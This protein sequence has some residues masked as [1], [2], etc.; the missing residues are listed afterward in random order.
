MVP[1]DF[2]KHHQLQHKKS[3]YTGKGL[4]GL[5]NTGNTCYMNTIIQC[6][7]N[8]LKLT[9][10]FLNK[11]PQ[12]EDPGR[13]NWN[14]FEYYVVLSYQN[15]LHN[16]WSDNQL[17][18]PRT[19]RENLCK[20]VKKYYNSTQQDAHECLTNILDIL[21][22]AL[23]YDI[24]VDIKGTPQTSVDHLMIQ[25]LQQWKSFYEKKYSAL[26]DFFYGQHHNKIICSGC[27]AESHNFD[28]YCG[29]S[30]SLSLGKDKGSVSLDD[31]FKDYFSQ[32]QIQTWNC[33][34]CKSQ[35]CTR[36]TTLWT[37]P[38]YLIVHLKRF[39][40][41]NNKINTPVIS[42]LDDLDL[43]EYMS[44][45]KSDPNNYIYSCYA[46]AHHSGNTNGGHYWADCR[47]LDG[48]WYTFNDGDVSQTKTA[49][50][51]SIDSNRTA[52]I[53]FYHRKFM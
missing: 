13:K 41:N 42:N 8:T 52:Y 15:L 39:D 25:S 12:E 5:M 40:N 33:E 36:K 51:L 3:F 32:K 28:P 6:L 46:I 34:K 10:Y 17:L 1:Y 24:V 50:R 19:F 4:S 49:D 21:H 43:T 53:L 27:K 16:M 9:D 2:H 22:T 35:G 45:D 20:F 11:K 48:N 44:T 31:C 23:C 37:L 47:N 30:L 38:N 7:S 18:K 14:R 26:I 29:L